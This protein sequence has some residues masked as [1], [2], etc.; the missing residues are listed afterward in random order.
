MTYPLLSGL[1][2]VPVGFKEGANVDSLAA[3]EVSMDR[4]VESELQGAPVE[5]AVVEETLI[6]DWGSTTGS[7]EPATT[8]SL[9]GVGRAMDERLGAEGAHRAAC[10][11]DMVGEAD[12][13]GVT[14]SRIEMGRMCCGRGGIES[15]ARTALQ[16]FGADGACSG[17]PAGQVGQRMS[18]GRAS[19]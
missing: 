11:D 13:V 1:G 2:D 8:R 17:C 19:I 7:R 16:G 4:P 9:A 15:S 12:C 6:S 14:R 3:P 10:R 18:S 5:G